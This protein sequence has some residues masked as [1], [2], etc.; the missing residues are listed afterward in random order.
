MPNEL[1]E[2]LTAPLTNAG[3]P[4]SAMRLVRWNDNDEAWELV[5]GSVVDTENRLVSGAVD[6]FSVFGAMVLDSDGDG[7]PTGGNTSISAG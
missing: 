5:I 3:E 7:I 6:S 2:H 1:Q 4:A